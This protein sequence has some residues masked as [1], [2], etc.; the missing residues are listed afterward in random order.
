VV[1]YV[2]INAFLTHQFGQAA[3]M[4]IVL[5]LLILGLAVLQFR[6]VNLEVEY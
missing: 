3:A 2:Y 1:Y 5:F 4:A 6:Y